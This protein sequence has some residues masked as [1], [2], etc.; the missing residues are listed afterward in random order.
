L[1]KNLQ[2]TTGDYFFA[3]PC[4]YDRCCCCLYRTNTGQQRTRPSN[5]TLSS[6][7]NRFSIVKSRDMS[8]NSFYHI[9]AL[10]LCKSSFVQVDDQQR[11]D[12]RDA[13]S[14]CSKNYNIYCYTSIDARSCEVARGE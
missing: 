13:T 7:T 5:W 6:T 9:S 2:N 4:T 3:A 8:P 10:A 11:S 12:C 1:L 14:S